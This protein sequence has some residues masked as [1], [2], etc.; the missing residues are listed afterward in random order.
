MSGSKVTKEQLR[1]AFSNS[2]MPDFEKEM[3][4]EPSKLEVENLNSAEK[5]TAVSPSGKPT[6][7]S[8]VINPKYENHPCVVCGKEG[9]CDCDCPSETN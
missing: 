9:N 5:E 3:S 2:K 6:E 4:L 1:E 7:Q 8:G